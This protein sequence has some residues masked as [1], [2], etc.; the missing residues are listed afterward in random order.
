MPALLSCTAFAA[1]SPNCWVSALHHSIGSTGPGLVVDASALSG[2]SAV[3]TAG[4]EVAGA[5]AAGSVGSTIAFCSSASGRFMVCSVLKVMRCTSMAWIV[6]PSMRLFCSSQNNTVFSSPMRFSS[7]AGSSVGAIHWPMPGVAG[8]APRIIFSRKSK[9]G[10]SLLNEAVSIMA[11]LQLG[12][13]AA[14]PLCTCRARLR[15]LQKATRCTL[16]PR[17]SSSRGNACGPVMC[18][19]PTAASTLRPC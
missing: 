19:A 10:T 1:S 13:G 11:F 8:P 5:G 16:K 15:Q 12:G 17:C 2:A 6:A 3:V 4:A 9:P 14:E 7:S 18:N